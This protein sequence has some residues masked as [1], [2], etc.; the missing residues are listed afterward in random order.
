MTAWAMEPQTP[1][2]RKF[3]AKVLLF[4]EHLVTI[5]GRG[6]AVP[7]HAMHCALADTAQEADAPMEGS[8]AVLTALCDHCRGLDW[9]DADALDRDIERGLTVSMDIP[10]GYGLGSS[11]ALVAAIYD[12]A[13]TDDVDEPLIVRERLGFMEGLFHGTSSGLD[14]IVSW[15]DRPVLVGRDRLNV[16]DRVDLPDDLVLID[17]GVSR[18][19]APQV[20]HVREL[21]RDPDL[22]R[23]IRSEWMVFDGEAI[24]AVLAGDRQRLGEAVALISAFQRDVLAGIIPEEMRR[25][26]DDAAAAGCHLKICGA[27]GGGMFLALG[28]RSVL[29]DT[30]RT[31]AL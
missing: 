30:L 18:R 3:P 11:G 19:T 16:L 31:I 4:G 1:R 25:V 26:W 15:L 20:E 13:G 7:L 2:M 6:L 27:G 5:G 28:D 10:V 14:P 22:Q 9:F 24:D 21:A 12:R 8:R 23:R 29:P 17:S